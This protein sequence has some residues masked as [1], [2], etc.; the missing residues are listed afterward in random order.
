MALTD[1][2]ALTGK[3][4]DLKVGQMFGKP[5]LLVGKKAIGWWLDPDVALKL[6]A[7]PR[8][9]ALALKGA[10]E[11]DAGNGRPM[12]EWIVIPQ[13][14]KDQWPRFAEAAYKYLTGK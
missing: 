1:F 14:F 5:S 10:H 8:E 4:P 6:P 3:K 7:G 11:Y 13:A 2:E 9:E 12:R